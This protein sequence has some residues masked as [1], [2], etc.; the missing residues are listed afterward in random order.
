M[1]VQL[2]KFVE[3]QV[4]F[5]AACAFERYARSRSKHQI[6][7]AAPRQWQIDGRRRLEEMPDR[8]RRS[9]HAQPADSSL[10]RI[11]RIGGEIHEACRVAAPSHRRWVVDPEQREQS[12]SEKGAGE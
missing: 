3:H 5:S 11:G 2:R 4:D 6:V 12:E 8:L 1:F 9:P 10:N 7:F